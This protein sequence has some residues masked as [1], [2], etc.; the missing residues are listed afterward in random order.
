MVRVV[1]PVSLQQHLDCHAQVAGGYPRV[2]A[3]LHEPGR[4][5]V[6]AYMG[7]DVPAEPGVAYGPVRG[8]GDAKDGSTVVF[9]GELLTVRSSRP[10]CS[11][12]MP[13]PAR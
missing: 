5:G 12:A 13:T 2:N 8:F 3:A 7:C 10:T 1:V 11:N 4:A 9:D 6:P